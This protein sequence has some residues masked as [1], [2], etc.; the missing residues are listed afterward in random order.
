[1]RGFPKNLNT[2]FDYEFVLAN[3]TDTAE[4][5]AKVKQEFQKLLDSVKGWFFVKDLPSA[6]AGIEDETHKVV[7]SKNEND[8]DTFTQYEL[9]D[10]PTC[11]LF[12]LGFTVAE[13][14]AIVDKL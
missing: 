12:K 11:K 4:G 2:K 14:Q 1:M 3:F 9:R 7:V 8:E 10:N 5:K 13:V 6:E